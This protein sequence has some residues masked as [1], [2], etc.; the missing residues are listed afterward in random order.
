MWVAETCPVAIIDLHLRQE[1]S[2]NVKRIKTS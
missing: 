1:K 2:D